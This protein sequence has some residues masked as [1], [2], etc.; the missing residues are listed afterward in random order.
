VHLSHTLPSKRFDDGISLSLRLGF[1]QGGRKRDVQLLRK[2]LVN[3]LETFHVI[4]ILR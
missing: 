3:K 4:T 1:I 2:P